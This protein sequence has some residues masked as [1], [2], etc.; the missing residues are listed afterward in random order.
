MSSRAYKV[1][2]HYLEMAHNHNM[3]MIEKQQ[4]ERKARERVELEE[5]RQQAEASPQSKA[6]NHEPVQLEPRSPLQSTSSSTSQQAEPSPRR[7][8]PRQAFVHP[9]IHSPTH[10]HIPPSSSTPLPSCGLVLGRIKKKQK[11]LAQKSRDKYSSSPT[12]SEGQPRET[13][14]EAEAKRVKGLYKRYKE[15]CIEGDNEDFNVLLFYSKCKPHLPLHYHVACQV[16]AGTTPLN[17]FQVS[18]VG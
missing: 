6:T 1:Y 13:A 9:T 10:T 7:E 5:A 16:Y 14:W 17:A 2:L 11:S 3:A 18:R 8:S 12:Q 4:Q 15:E